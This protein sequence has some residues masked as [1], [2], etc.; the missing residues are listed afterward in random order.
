MAYF[1]VY[2]CQNLQPRHISNPISQVFLECIHQKPSSTRC[3]PCHHSY[4]RAQRRYPGSLM[5]PLDCQVMGCATWTPDIP[6][7][8]YSS[9]RKVLILDAYLTLSHQVQTPCNKT[10]FFALVRCRGAQLPQSS[11]GHHPS[12][13]CW[14]KKDGFGQEHL[15]LAS[16]VHSL[17]G[18]AKLCRFRGLAATSRHKA[19]QKFRETLLGWIQCCLVDRTQGF[20]LVISSV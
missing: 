10:D 7:K 8:M 16:H 5:S 14:V 12:A 20:V 17:E 6:E 4:P 19:L 18:K 1:T 9:Q 11:Y 2:T 3:W 15:L 13:L